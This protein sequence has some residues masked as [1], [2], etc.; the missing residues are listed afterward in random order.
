MAA[1]QLG[2]PGK[3]L[4]AIK[5]ARAF[6]AKDVTIGSSDTS[7]IDKQGV[8]L[9]LGDM[10]NQI[11]NTRL[12]QILTFLLGNMPTGSSP[13]FEASLGRLVH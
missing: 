9:T 10:P 1:V 8:Q 7:V 4:G 11:A 13:K 2:G 3:N 5:G 6:V 12:S